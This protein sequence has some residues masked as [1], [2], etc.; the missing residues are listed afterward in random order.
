PRP[1]RAGLHRRLDAGDDLGPVEGLAHARAL[2][3]RQARG[4]RPLEG[5]EPLPAGQALP[6]PADRTAAVGLARIHH[7]GVVMTTGRAAHD[8]KAI[9]CEAT[10]C[11]GG[12]VTAVAHSPRTTAVRAPLVAALRSARDV[13]GPAHTICCNERDFA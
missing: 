7:R 13:G 1:D 11:R 10:A 9:G 12:E 6:A 4:L 8:G 2:D 3:D 5:R